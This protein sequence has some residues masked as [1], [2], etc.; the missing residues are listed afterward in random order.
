[1]STFY[2]YDE[3]GMESSRRAK[4]ARAIPLVEL[5]HLSLTKAFFPNTR[6]RKGGRGFD[7]DGEQTG[8]SELRSLGVC[9]WSSHRSSGHGNLNVDA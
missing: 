7:D 4:R 1:M 6:F 2:M 8:L 5:N 9:K 3:K